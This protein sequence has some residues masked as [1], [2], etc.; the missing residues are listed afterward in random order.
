MSQ[1]DKKENVVVMVGRISEFHKRFSLALKIWQKI[2]DR[3]RPFLR[4]ILKL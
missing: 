2:R 3:I 1:H 4:G